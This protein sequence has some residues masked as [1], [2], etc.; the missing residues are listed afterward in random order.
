MLWVFAFLLLLFCFCFLSSFLFFILFL[1]SKRRG[2]EREVGTHSYSST[3]CPNHSHFLRTFQERIFRLFPPKTWAFKSKAYIRLSIPAW[4]IL[5]FSYPTYTSLLLR[6]RSSVSAYLHIPSKVSPLEEPL[7]SLTRLSFFPAEQ[8]F[9]VL[10]TPKFIPYLHRRLVDSRTWAQLPSSSRNSECMGVPVPAH[11]GQCFLKA[12]TCWELA[13]YIKNVTPVLIM[14]KCYRLYREGSVYYETIV[15]SASI[16]PLQKYSWILHDNLILWKYMQTVEC[17]Y[18]VIIWGP[19]MVH[20]APWL[21]P[22]QP[23]AVKSWKTPW[24]TI[25]SPLICH[26]IYHTQPFL[27]S[28]LCSL[29]MLTPDYSSNFVRINRFI[30]FFHIS[31]HLTINL[32]ECLHFSQANLKV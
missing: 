28:L 1:F 14:A 15:I 11:S 4:Y 8:G 16:F 10:H 7:R 21:T 5:F 18:C 27:C 32:F 20:C 13:M 31:I 19:R 9:C 23:S 22:E 29:V 26:I 6:R 30:F 17:I 3:L 2:G 12:Q 25:S 24:S